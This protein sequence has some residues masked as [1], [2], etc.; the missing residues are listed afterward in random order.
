MQHVYAD[1]MLGWVVKLCEMAVCEGVL[2][3]AQLKRRGP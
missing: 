3:L 1:S 2:V